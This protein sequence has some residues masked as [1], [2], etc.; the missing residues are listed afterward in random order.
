MEPQGLFQLQT[1]TLWEDHIYDPSH[2]SQ[3]LATY[4]LCIGY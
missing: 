3:A 2:K 4:V 1:G